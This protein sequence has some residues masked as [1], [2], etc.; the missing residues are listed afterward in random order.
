M[1]EQGESAN[2][3]AFYFFPYNFLGQFTKGY[4]AGPRYMRSFYMRFRVYAIEK[5]PFFLEPIL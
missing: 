5:W 3:I 1:V 4:T 2:L